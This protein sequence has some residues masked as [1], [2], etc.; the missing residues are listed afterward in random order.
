MLGQ[1]AFRPLPRDGFEL[2]DASLL[3]GS[4]VST[5]RLFTDL[6]QFGNL[7]VRQIMALQPQGLHLLLHA[8]MGMVETFVMKCF[9]FFFRESDGKHGE[10]SEEEWSCL[11]KTFSFLYRPLFTVY[12]SQIFNRARYNAGKS[13]IISI[14]G[15]GTRSGAWH[16]LSSR[17]ER[18]S[19]ILKNESVGLNMAA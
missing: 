14:F 5:Q 6:D 1:L 11:D 19:F 18:C 8:W 10:H 17:I 3:V 15:V 7:S 2:F 13:S 16:W 4:Q 9:S 12:K